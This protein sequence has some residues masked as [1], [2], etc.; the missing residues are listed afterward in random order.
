MQQ[1][2]AEQQIAENMKTKRTM[3]FHGTKNP[4][5]AERSIPVWN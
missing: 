5:V 3:I 2:G 4:N 1:V